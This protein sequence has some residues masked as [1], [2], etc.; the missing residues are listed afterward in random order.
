MGLETLNG[1]PKEVGS[2]FSCCHNNLETLNGCPKE[3]GDDFICYGNNEVFTKEHVKGHC[4]VKGQI[5]V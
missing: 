3:V 4:D 1:C 5:I 2:T